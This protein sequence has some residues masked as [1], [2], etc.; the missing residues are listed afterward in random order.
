MPRGAI[1]GAQPSPRNDAPLRGSGSVYPSLVM[2][3]FPISAAASVIE[4]KADG[5][6][7]ADGEDDYSGWMSI[8]A[9]PGGVRN[10]RPASSAMA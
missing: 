9:P 8:S 4:L 7:T 2:Q 6:G 5:T 3:R 10:C 1:L